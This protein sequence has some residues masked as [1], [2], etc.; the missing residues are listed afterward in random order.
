MNKAEAGMTSAIAEAICS[1]SFKD[2]PQEVIQVAKK[3]LLDCTGVAIAG[4]LEQVSEI[5]RDFAL[6]MGSGNH[7][8]WG[9]PERTSA[10]VAA[11]AN[12]TAAHALDFDD[13]NQSMT[14][15][16]TAPIWPAVFSTAVEAG[17]S[18]LEALEAYIVGL[19]M[20]G[21]LG[22]VV[23]PA[24]HDAGWH[25]TAILCT[26]GAAAA[27]AKL[28]K[29]D[30]KATAYALGIAS[31]MAGGI[32]RNFGTMVKP[33]HVGM[34]AFH[35]ASAAWLAAKG[36]T[37]NRDIFTGETGFIHVFAPGTMNDPQI[38]LD[39][40]GE[41]WEILDPGMD[42]KPYPSCRATHA[43]IDCVIHLIEKYNI[44]PENISSIRAGV[45]YTRPKV[46]VYDRP[47][48]PLEAKFSMPYCLS[49][50]ANYRS[51][52]LEHF[53]EE[54]LHDPGILALMPKVEMYVHPDMQPKPGVNP[55]LEM[56][57]AEVTIELVTGERY[58]HRVKH[59]K[60]H[61]SVPMTEEEFMEKF[62]SCTQA[63]TN[64]IRKRIMDSIL[65]LDQLRSLSDLNDLLSNS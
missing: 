37:S 62:N 35:G 4:A 47:S 34:A 16:P 29:L 43:S 21:K 10:V 51:V 36:M 27:C 49:V 2:I 23:N 64:D 52:K 25:P 54:S 38:I 60:G 41:K 12:G 46:L 58:S 20:A 22:R 15:H 6:G 33:L 13:S 63:L 24:H 48:N 59:G 40:W 44:N 5:V 55:A 31:S 65:N 18:G 50:A 14:G 53:K 3:N 1:L 28:L 56:V 57:G 61:P 8:I 7:A 30:V 26:I 9:R 45:N 39:R 19:E 42:I 11:L 17:A 32:R